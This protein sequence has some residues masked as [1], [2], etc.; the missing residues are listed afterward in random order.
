MRLEPGSVK[1]AGARVFVSGE[2][3]TTMRGSLVLP[4]AGAEYE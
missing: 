1:V 4:P 3:V 2:A